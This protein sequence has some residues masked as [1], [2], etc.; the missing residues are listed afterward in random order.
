MSVVGEIEPFDHVI[1]ADTGDEPE[2]VYTNLEWWKK[3]FTQEGVEFHIVQN[4]R[5]P[6]SGIIEDSI[7]NRGKSIPIPAFSLQPNGSK[8]ITPRQCTRDWKVT[9]IMR[10]VKEILGIA[11]KR[12][13]HITEILAVQTLGI[14]WDEAQ[15]MR[16]SAHT[17]LVHDYP[18]IDRRLDRTDCIAMMSQDDRF[19]EPARS[20][21]W[22]CP[23]HSDKEWRY[24]RD[25]EPEA[26]A[27]A[28]D[29]DTRLRGPEAMKLSKLSGA[30]FLHSS[31]KPLAEIDF[32]NEEDKGQMTLFD[33]ECQGMCGI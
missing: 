12:H 25:Q 26:F 7:A 32:D 3:R 31:C 15:R 16:D 4:K 22:H 8:G 20:A 30:L 2:S 1:F 19:P 6:I 10:R 24:L 27:K 5:G 28:V 21:C 33:N 29:L 14:S 17:W 18:L 13:N 9:E 23:F 11:G